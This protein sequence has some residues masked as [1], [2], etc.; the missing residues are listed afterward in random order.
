MT[1]NLIP[2][3]G[4]DSHISFAQ[5]RERRAVPPSPSIWLDRTPRLLAHRGMSTILSGMLGVGKAAR[6]SPALLVSLLFF[7]AVSQSAESA[8][9]EA[10]RELIRDPHFQQGFWALEPQLGK[11]V[12]SVR[13][14]GWASSAEP[15]WDLAQWSSKYPLDLACRHEMGGW[16]LAWTNAAK[17]VLLGSPGAPE[18]EL[19]LAVEASAEYGARARRAEEPWVHLLVQQ[20]FIDPPSLSELASAR[21]RLQVRLLR[22]QLART[23]DYSPDRHAAQYQAFFTVQNRNRTSPGFG[24]YLWFG[25]PLYDDRHRSP[26]AHTAKD[27]G[28]TGMFIYTPPGTAYTSHSAHDRQWIQI[29]RDLLPLMREGL[30]TAWAQGFL[31]Q[32]KSLA[33]YR[34]TGMNLGWEVPGIFNVALAVKGMSLTVIPQPSDKQAV[35]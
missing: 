22:S 10:G 3:A 33:D 27:T 30:A 19:V 7:H 9:S 20:E 31:I 24:Q 29:D 6:V 1:G 17:A 12:V 4:A 35:K 11:R 5:M 8:T 16:K 25:V 21:L 34:I 18:G 23:E 26:G 13:L 32:S 28:G 2:F 14:P 15:V